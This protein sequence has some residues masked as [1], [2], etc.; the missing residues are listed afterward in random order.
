[1][2]LK[3]PSPS[4]SHPFLHLVKRFYRGVGWIGV[5][6]TLLLSAIAAFDLLG[7][8]TPET[9]LTYRLLG[10]FLSFI[11]LTVLGLFLSG[12]AFLISACIDAALHSMEN[13]RAQTELL[14]RLVREQSDMDASSH[15]MEKGHSQTEQLYP[16]SHEQSDAQSR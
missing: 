15:L 16:A 5:A 13:G 12:L 6:L 1:M 8:M 2:A 9:L 14:R 7:R 10:A 4:P 11:G 3:S